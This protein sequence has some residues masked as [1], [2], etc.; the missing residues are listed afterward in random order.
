[1]KYICPICG[2]VY[3][4][5]KEGRPFAELPEDWV[6]PVCTAPKSLFEPA[7]P[8]PETPAASASPAADPDGGELRRISPGV[9]AAI[10]SN[11]ARGCEKQYKAPEAALYQELAD[12]FTPAGTAGTGGRA[13]PS[14]RNAGG[15][16]VRRL[17]AAPNSRRSRSRP[18]HT[19]GA[20]LGAE[21]HHHAAL[22]GAAVPAARGSHAGKTPRSG[23]VPSAALSILGKSP[24]LSARCARCR[25]GNLKK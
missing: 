17:S 15:G 19:A 14:G 21:G 11:L 12:Y 16:S 22:P 2:Y 1:M 20:H 9:I 3:D 25:L 24:R 4:E 7:A 13:R 10:C 23:S 18:R 8:A 5:E 6:C